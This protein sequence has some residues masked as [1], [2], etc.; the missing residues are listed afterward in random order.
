MLN[1]PTQKMKGVEHGKVTEKY[2]DYNIID[3]ETTYE[4]I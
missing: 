1:T 4:S 3:V 2:I